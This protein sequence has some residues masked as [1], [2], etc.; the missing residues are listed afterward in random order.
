MEKVAFLVSTYP[1]NL[2]FEASSRSRA[3]AVREVGMGLFFKHILE[4][5]EKCCF[6]DKSNG[7]SVI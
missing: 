2:T 6:S 7:S 3:V 1:I 5:G 4:I